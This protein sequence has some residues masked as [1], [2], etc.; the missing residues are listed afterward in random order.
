MRTSSHSFVF[1]RSLPNHSKISYKQ[2]DK[3]KLN[4]TVISDVNNIIFDNSK[5]NS[6]KNK[7]KQ[8]DD[9]IKVKKKKM[10]NDILDMFSKYEKLEKLAES[11]EEKEEEVQFLTQIV[12]EKTQVMT[13]WNW[14]ILIQMIYYWNIRM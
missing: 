10:Y 5:A 14:I 7:R 6:I 13:R 1:N 9:N 3:Q 2:K 8:E 11:K 12:D 4:I